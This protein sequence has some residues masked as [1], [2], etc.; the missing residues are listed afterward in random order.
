MSILTRIRD[1]VDELFRILELSCHAKYDIS[2]A[3]DEVMT[4]LFLQKVV[5]DQNRI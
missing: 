3:K 2:E 5:P 1:M 4:R